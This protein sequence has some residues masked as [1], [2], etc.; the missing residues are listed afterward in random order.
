MSQSLE[1]SFNKNYLA[2]ATILYMET[3]TSVRDEAS[4][5][6][7]GFFKKVLIS[8]DIDDTLNVF[9]KNKL[10]IDLVLTDIDM[11]QLGGIKIL[12]EIR[13]ID[14]NVPILITTSFNDTNLLLKAVKFNPV[15]YIIKPMQLNN[16]LKTISE[17]MKKKEE[18]KDIDVKNNELRQFMS[19]LDTK[20][21]ICE[22]DV[23]FK[24]ISA[25]DLFLMN[26]GYKLD[27]I[28]GKKFDS[29][30]IFDHSEIPVFEIK[31]LATTGKTW[32]GLTKKI[33]KDRNFYYT[34][35]TILPIFYNDGR[36]KKFIEFATVITKYECEIISLKKHIM[37][38]KSE[39]FKTS[40]ELKKE[41]EYYK[42]LAQSLKSQVDEKLNNSQHLQSELIELKNNNAA[43]K[44]KL[45][46]QEKRFEEFQATILSG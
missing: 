12:S 15:D 45:Q 25:N 41:N 16:I 5:I 8:Q 14:L 38:L 10:E 9:T 6:F 19:I 30:L 37:L 44:E 24:I 21:I 1:C 13:N 2:D 17:I 42:T 43:L 18:N 29:K 23:N 26:S 35:S 46:I 34:Y 3:D 4:E 40:I 7:A 32:V 27:E 28:I 22:M 20:N 11:P 33:T 36:I 39:N 31:K